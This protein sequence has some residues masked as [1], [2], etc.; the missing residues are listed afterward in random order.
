MEFG[1]LHITEEDSNVTHQIHFCF[2]FLSVH[3]RQTDEEGEE[4]EWDSTE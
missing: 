4:S 3:K 1:H 2:K